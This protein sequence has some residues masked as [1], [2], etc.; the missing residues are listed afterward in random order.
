MAIW[1]GKRAATE[2]LSYGYHRAEVIG[3]LTSVVL[4]WYFFQLIIFLGL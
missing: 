1:I 2:K 4:I 3:A